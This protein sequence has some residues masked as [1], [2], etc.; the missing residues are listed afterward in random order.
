MGHPFTNEV[1]SDYWSSTTL[2]RSYVMPSITNSHIAWTVGF[3][4]GYVEY[5]Y[6][7][8]SALYVRAVRGGQ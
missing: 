1:T 8:V 7:K 3:P 5:G 6:G 2:T 4:N